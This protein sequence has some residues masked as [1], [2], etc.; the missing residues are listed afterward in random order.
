MY[1]NIKWIIPCEHCFHKFYGRQRSCS[2]NLLPDEAWKQKPISKHACMPAESYQAS[3]AWCAPEQLIGDPCTPATDM[4]AMGVIMWELCTGV[5]ATTRRGYRPVTHPQEAPEAIAHVI[6]RCME[7]EPGNRPDASELHDIIM[8]SNNAEEWII[9]VVLNLQGSIKTWHIEI[10]MGNQC[11][12]HQ[13]RWDPGVWHLLVRLPRR[14]FMP[15]ISQRNY[16]ISIVACVQYPLPM[17][18]LHCTRANTALFAIQR[19]W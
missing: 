1:T 10:K 14:P 7:D 12:T 19:L 4:F 9:G 5:Q 16:Y 2:N 13:L 6:K 11:G 8:A 15:Q 3:F 18:P 17:Y